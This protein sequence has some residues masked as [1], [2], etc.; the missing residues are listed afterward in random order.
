MNE[1]SVKNL[2]NLH[3][4]LSLYTL[5]LTTFLHIYGF[6]LVSQGASTFYPQPWQSFHAGPLSCMHSLNNLPHHFDSRNNKPRLFMVYHPEKP[7]ACCMFPILQV[8]IYTHARARTRACVCVYI[9]TYT[10][11]YLAI[12][13]KATPAY[14]DSHPYAEPRDYETRCS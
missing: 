13:G 1:L 5:S 3:R 2:R 9:Y 10:Y 8:F 7:W 6:S 4:C 14:K 12:H 11:T